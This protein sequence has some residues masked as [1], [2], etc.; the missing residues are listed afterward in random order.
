MHRTAY[1]LVPLLASLLI[2]GC[3][4]DQSIYPSLARRDAERVSGTLEPVKP[5]SDPTA[6]PT[7]PSAELSARLNQLTSLAQAAHSK[8]QSR[9][10]K[11]RQLARSAAG[12]ALAS[13]SWAVATVALADLESARSEAMIA[14]ADL[15]ILHSAAVVEGRDAAAIAAARDAVTA[16]VSQ[17]D[18]VLAELRDT[19]AR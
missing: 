3:A 8:F 12:A 10:A 4:T 16:L 9:E 11:A 13:E 19:L 18:R 7:P 2:A 17:E 6:T 5:T 1:P 14:L 15:D